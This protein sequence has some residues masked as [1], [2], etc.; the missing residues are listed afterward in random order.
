MWKFLVHYYLEDNQEFEYKKWSLVHSRQNW[1]YEPS[2]PDSGLCALLNCC[3]IYY[4]KLLNQYK[5]DVFK[6]MRMHILLFLSTQGKILLSIF[7][8]I[9][10]KS[11]WTQKER[12]KEN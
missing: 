1:F 2:I 10:G 11:L 8:L 7:A 12:K 4:C 9:G 5:Q 3:G 6:K